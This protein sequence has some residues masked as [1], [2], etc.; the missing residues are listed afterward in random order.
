MSRLTYF[1]LFIA[2]RQEE[3]D[4][5]FKEIRQYK[6]TIHDRRHTFYYI[7]FHPTI[8]SPRNGIW[9]WQDGVLEGPLFSSHAETWDGMLRSCLRHLLTLHTSPFDGFIYSGHGGA[10]N[11]GR[12]VRDS[13]A[14]FKWCDVIALFEKH[15]LTFPVM[16]FNSCYMGSFLSLLECERIT[17]WVAADPGYSCWKSLTT[18][19]AFW[20][21]SRAIGSWLQDAT[22]EYGKQYNEC[23]YHCFMVFDVQVVSPLF[24]EMKKTEPLLWNWVSP[25]TSYDRSSYD[26][27]SLLEHTKNR[28]IHDDKMIRLIQRMMRFSPTCVYKK[29]PSIQLGRILHM[30]HRYD[31]SRWWDFWKTVNPYSVNGT[32]SNV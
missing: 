15:H 2:S 19:R 11:I 8:H 1:C 24:H 14:F 22:I 3:S 4:E 21:R 10:V 16:I 30:E 29:G 23:K 7:A 26:L 12:W 17:S 9:K 18:T 13:S 5:F 28:S 20:K 25:V 27:L 31:G 6:W 32:M